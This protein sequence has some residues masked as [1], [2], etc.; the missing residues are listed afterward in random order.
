MTSNLQSVDDFIKEHNALRKANKNRWLCV[1][2]VI[3]GHR[4]AIKSYNTWIQLLR[5]EP[6]LETLPDTKGLH[7]FKDSGPMD[8]SVKDYNLYLKESLKCFS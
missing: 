4:V 3:S 5:V 2:A 6:L 8:C 7:S 1:S